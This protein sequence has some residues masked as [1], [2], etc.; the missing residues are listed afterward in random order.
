MVRFGVKKQRIDELGGFVRFFLHCPQILSGF[1]GRHASVL[2]CL[3]IPPY[4]RQRRFQIMRNIRNDALLVVLR[5]LKLLHQLEKIIVCRHQLSWNAMHAVGAFAAFLACGN[6]SVER[7][8][9]PA[10]H[11]HEHHGGNCRE[12]NRDRDRR[13]PNHPVLA[14]QLIVCCFAHIRGDK[15]KGAGLIVDGN[16][17]E[18]LDRFV[19]AEFPVY[20]GKL[21]LAQRFA[22]GEQVAFDDRSIKLANA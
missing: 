7:L 14:D 5:G 21:P 8:C 13:K 12:G 22:T 10:Y 2:E 1:F 19:C 17:F 9:R 6:G 4:H 15:N 20:Q 18:L 11:S 3:R 16:V